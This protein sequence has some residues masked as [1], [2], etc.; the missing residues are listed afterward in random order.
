MITAIFSD[1]D[2]TISK[3]DVGYNIFHHFSGGRNDAILPDWKS[4]KMTTRECLNMEAEMVHA[5]KEE[6]LKFID[7]FDIDNHFKTFVDKCREADHPL[8]L[9]SDGLSFY[10]E[11]ILGK[12]GLSHLKFIANVGTLENNS[13]TVSYPYDNK[14]CKRCGI[15]KGERLR[16]F[17]ESCKE[18]CRTV[19][20][21]DGYSDACAAAEADILFAKKDLKRYCTDKNISFFSYNDFGDVIK[22]LTN[23]GIF[24][25]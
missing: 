25:G 7:D 12:N 6:I 21:G 13:I 1:F 2:G 24:A 19:F 22:E 10:I 9:L 4:G 5:T 8:M 14:S 15:C 11:H 3:R 16:D 20:I 23:L 17:K 18:E